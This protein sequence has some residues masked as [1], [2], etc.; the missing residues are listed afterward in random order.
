M[1]NIIAGLLITASMTAHAA[2]FATP[3]DAEALVG[4]AVKAIAADKDGT[5]KEITNKEAKW[6]HGD[7]YPWVMDDKYVM[8]AHGTNDKLI[9][10]SME[11]LEDIDGKQFVKEYVQATLAKGRSWTD[12]KYTD[13][14][15]KKVLPKAAYCE[16]ASGLIVCAGVYK[17]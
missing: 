14:V 15:S 17:R 16:K 3:K 6:V 10:K 1:K 7:L 12:F 11:G 9:G 13:P 8:L 4:K 2:E 5:L